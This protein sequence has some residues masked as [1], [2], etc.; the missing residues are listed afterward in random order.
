M[1]R[2]EKMKTNH[3][4]RLLIVLL[5][6][7]MLFVGIISPNFIQK[8]YADDTEG[9]IDC[10]SLLTGNDI[11]DE[12]IEQIDEDMTELYLDYIYLDGNHIWLETTPIE[13]KYGSIILRE[14]FTTDMIHIDDEDDYFHIATVRM[15]HRNMGIMN[16]LVDDEDGYIDE[17]FEFFFWNTPET[18]SRFR[19]WNFKLTWNKLNVNFDDDLSILV[20]MI[21]LAIQSV[22][23][24][25][26]PDDAISVLNREEDM[27]SDLIIDAIEEVPLGLYNKFLNFFTLEILLD[28][29][30]VVDVVSIILNNSSIVTKIVSI[31]FSVF[32]PS[33]E[34]CIY[35]LYNCYVYNSSTK[36][37][38]CWIPTLRDR[39]GF[40]I[41]VI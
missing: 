18:T 31:F 12:Y 28:I 36:T 3:F 17:N 11:S 22:F 19:A 25:S 6:F 4:N 24:V 34:D 32:F 30:S 38:L 8:S 37:Q 21:A 27:V 40:K 10:A 26:D 16:D 1:E 15:I 7:V 29:A 20:A 41:E 23:G 14:D 13:E 33:E 35:I 39:F 2:G 9:E 5:S